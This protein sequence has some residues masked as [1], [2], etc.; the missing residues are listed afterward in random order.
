MSVSVEHTELLCGGKLRNYRSQ[1]ESDSV[2]SL[3]GVSLHDVE[4]EGE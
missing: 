2:L 1:K 4:S 3:S